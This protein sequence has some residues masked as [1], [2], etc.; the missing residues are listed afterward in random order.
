LKRAREAPSSRA[1]GPARRWRGG[2]E[3]ARLA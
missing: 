2:G 3:A 1:A